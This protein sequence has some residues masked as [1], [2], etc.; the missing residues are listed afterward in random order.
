MLMQ[1]R[2]YTAD[3]ELNI[4]PGYQRL[5]KNNLRPARV[6]AHNVRRKSRLKMKSFIIGQTYIEAAAITVQKK[7]VRLVWEILPQYSHSA[8]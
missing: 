3:L 4:E 5:E 8:P 6:K 1:R 7:P 2:T